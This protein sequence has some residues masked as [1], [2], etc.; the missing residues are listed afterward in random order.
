MNSFIVSLTVQLSLNFHKRQ[1]S[2]QLTALV[3]HK[4]W[5]LANVAMGVV[6]VI[7]FAVE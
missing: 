2:V 5:R 7:R 6:G 4:E 3:L 1:I